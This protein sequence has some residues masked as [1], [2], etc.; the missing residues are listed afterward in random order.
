MSRGKSPG[1]DGLSIKHLEYAGVHLP[2]MLAMLFNLC[3]RHSYFPENHIKTVIVPIVKNK[4]VSDMNKYRPISLATVLAK[5]DHT[6][7]L[8]NAP[9]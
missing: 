3:L 2:H 7:T 5:V 6:H 1:H 9:T 8:H 4:T